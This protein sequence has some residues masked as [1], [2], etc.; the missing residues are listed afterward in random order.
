MRGSPQSVLM[1]DM[2]C[3]YGVFCRHLPNLILVLVLVDPHHAPE[4]A[5]LRLNCTIY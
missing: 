2:L 3:H 5:K 1:F 4:E